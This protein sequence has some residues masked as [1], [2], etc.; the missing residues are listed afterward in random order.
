ME[1]N[2]STI[3]HSEK[4]RIGQNRKAKFVKKKIACVETIWQIYVYL[5]CLCP[6]RL[7]P[8]KNRR[9]EYRGFA[10]H[11]KNTSSV[12]R[13]RF[14]LYAAKRRPTRLSGVFSV[15]SNGKHKLQKSPVACKN[16][17]GRRKHSTIYETRIIRHVNAR[18]RR[19]PSSI[20]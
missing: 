4:M 19:I 3:K 7:V 6:S 9:W 16:S 12:V 10:T 17:H 11:L 1:T 14:T 2:W 5:I 13:P 18:T 20:I 15:F 8:L